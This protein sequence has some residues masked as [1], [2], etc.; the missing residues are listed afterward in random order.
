MNII[1]AILA[2]DQ[3]EFETRLRAAEAF[4]DIVQI[5]IL[6]NTFVPFSSWADPAIIKTLDTP[7]RFELHLMVE[8]VEKYLNLWSPIPNVARAIFH[9]EACN[10]RDD[11][12]GD[13]LGTIAFYGWDAGLAINPETPIDKIAPFV[14]KIDTALFLGV[15][16]GQ[17]GQPFQPAVIEKIRAFKAAHPNSPS[18][19]VDGGVNADTIPTLKAAGA[20]TFCVASAIFGAGDPKATFEKLKSL[21]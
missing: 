19:A 1:P 15:N 20:E 16:P 11:D 7:L 12:A 2:K 6:D 9:V 14:D 10:G 18:V 8:D 3:T 5:D 4:T 21:L 17:S 13:L